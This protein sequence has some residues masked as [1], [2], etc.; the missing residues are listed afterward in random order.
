MFKHYVHYTSHLLNHICLIAVKYDNNKY[1]NSVGQ[2]KRKAQHSAV[3]TSDLV[4]VR[5][6]NKNHA[7]LFHRHPQGVLQL[8][9]NPAAIS[10]TIRK[11]VLMNNHKYF[12]TDLCLLQDCKPQFALYGHLG[13]VSLSAQKVKSCKLQQQ[14]Q[15]MSHYV[16]YA[17]YPHFC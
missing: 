8:C 11:Q 16:S 4:I 14:K 12:T 6:R 10:V 17:S 2:C 3:S 5:I 15:H 13:L 1:T 9:F 7:L